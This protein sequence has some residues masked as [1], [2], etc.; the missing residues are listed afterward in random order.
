[1]QAR[2]KEDYYG[3]YKGEVKVDGK[4]KKV[5]ESCLTRVGAKIE[6]KKWKKKH[7]PKEFEI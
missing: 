5:T 2:I 3:F 6:L 4:W 7:F 1:M